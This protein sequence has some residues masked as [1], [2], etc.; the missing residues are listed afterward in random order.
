VFD[1]KRE[2]VT[3]TWRKMNMKQLYGS[4]HSPNIICMIKVRKMRWTEHVTRMWKKMIRLQGFSWKTW[5]MESVRKSARRQKVN[6]KTW[7]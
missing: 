3:G 6:I 1:P 4:Y 5:R 7:S 2:T